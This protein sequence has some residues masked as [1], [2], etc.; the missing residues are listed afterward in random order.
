MILR[1]ETILF[2]AD[3]T[4][5]DFSRSEREALAQV[6]LE[7]GLPVRDE[8]ICAYSEIN[9]VLWK[10]LE[11]GEIQKSVLFGRRF[12][13]LL[14]RFSMGGDACAM[15]K[16]YMELVS[17]KGYLLEGALSLCHRLSQHSRLYIVTNGTEW[18]Q[19]SRLAQSGLLPVIRDVFI[20]DRIGFPKP[21]VEFFRYVAEHIPAFDP[22][23]TVIVGDSLTSDMAGGIAFGID[24]CWYNPERESAP[25]EMRGALT[26]VV[27]DFEELEKWL[28]K[29]ETV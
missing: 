29:G 24:T 12:E 25:A 6:L 15:G 28:T 3:G 21:R 2:D 13:L 5:L 17:Q 11:R 8:V 16:R 26:A 9:D 10:A 19:Q 1:Y 18:I 22:A 14:E 20:S 7:A 23:R 27:S 4:L